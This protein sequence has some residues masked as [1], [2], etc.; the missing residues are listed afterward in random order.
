VPSDLERA[1][2]LLQALVNQSYNSESWNPVECHVDH[3]LWDALKR[4]DRI[5]VFQILVSA[6]ARG[7]SAHMRHDDDIGELVADECDAESLLRIAKED[8]WYALRIG[9]NVSPDRPGFW[10][11]ALGLV[12]AYPNDQEIESALSAS[13]IYGQGSIWGPM[14]AHLARRAEAVEAVLPDQSTPPV[15]RRWLS[16][17]ARNLRLAASR[18]GTEEADRSVNW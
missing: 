1:F 15:A 2:R 4:I 12:E 17:L 8:R 9:A 3:L 6:G 16:E 7:G 11:I 10:L 18:E 5:R 13:I 14:A